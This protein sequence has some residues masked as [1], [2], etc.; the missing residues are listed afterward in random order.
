M[1]ATVVHQIFQVAYISVMATF[2]V[3]YISVMAM[4]IL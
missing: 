2:Q 4:V 3:A 1:K